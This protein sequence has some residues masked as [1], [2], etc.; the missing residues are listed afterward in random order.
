LVASQ[1]S[2]KPRTGQTPSQATISK[3]KSAMSDPSRTKYGVSIAERP[4]KS[5]EEILQVYKQKQ[6]GYYD[7]QD[8]FDEQNKKIQYQLSRVTN[9]SN[10]T[11]VRVERLRGSI[12]RNNSD[13]RNNELRALVLEER[14]KER[15]TSAV[16]H[17]Q[18]V[19][20][21]IILMQEIMSYEL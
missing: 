7:P 21:E 14:Q 18:G 17:M 13:A 2:V 1:L 6:F 8:S 16:A 4:A 9:S 19:L 15:E 11:N 3:L 20:A 5:P 12:G 10:F